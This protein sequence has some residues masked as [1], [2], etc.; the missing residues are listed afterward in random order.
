MATHDPRVFDGITDTIT[1]LASDWDYENPVTAETYLF[2]DLGF[3]SLDLVVLGASLQE[4]YGRLPFAELLAEIGQR[5]TQDI[6][7]GELATFISQH[8]G[9]PV[10]GEIR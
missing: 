2:G 7:V 3:E 9:K 10:T 4:K 5:E 1:E 8:A 6:S